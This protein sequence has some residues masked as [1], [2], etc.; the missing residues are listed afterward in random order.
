MSNEPKTWEQAA[1]RASHILRGYAGPWSNKTTEAF[2]G[3]LKLEVDELVD[4]F[5]HEYQPATMFPTSFECHLGSISDCALNMLQLRSGVNS[6]IWMEKVVLLAARKQHDYGHKNVTRFGVKGLIVRLH[7]KYARLANLFDKDFA[8]EIE[9]SVED[10]LLDVVGY[11]LIGVML[12]QGTFELNLSGS[13]FTKKKP[14]AKVEPTDIAQALSSVYGAWGA[15]PNV[16]ME[17]A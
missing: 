14:T 13:L 17:D 7:D 2:L 15:M 12:D 8:P 16:V 11:S 1:E 9:E 4:E 10:T 5:Y 3:V 6:R